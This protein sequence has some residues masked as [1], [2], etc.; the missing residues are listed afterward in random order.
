ME[1]HIL[2]RW[3]KLLVIFMVIC[4]VAICVGA[5]PLAGKELAVKY[6]EFAYCYYPWLVFL[7]I[8]ALPCFAA[9]RLAWKIFVNIEKDHSFCMENADYLK[10]ISFLAGADAGILFF[11]NILFL[12]LILIFLFSDNTAIINANESINPMI[13]EDTEE[14]K[15]YYNE[16]IYFN[17]IL[18]GVKKIAEV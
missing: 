15:A 4:G 11:G 14:D 2:V 12:L 6:P 8:M 1:Q 9:L 7:W 10:N 3:L 18:L 5:L 17:I 16:Y 13:M